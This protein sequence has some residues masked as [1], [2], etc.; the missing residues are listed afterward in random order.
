MAIGLV[1][2]RGKT[3]C[4]RK[5]TMENCINQYVWAYVLTKA[6]CVC[7]CVHTHAHMGMCT[8]FFFFVFFKQT[9]V[10]CSNFLSSILNDEGIVL[11]CMVQGQV[12]LTQRHC[13]MQPFLWRWGEDD[14]SWVVHR[15]F[16]GCTSCMLPRHRLCT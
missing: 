7:V 11:N 15:G 3:T 10:H 8:S 13:L 2:S 9:T 14:K 12:P 6:C 5:L 4:A 1:Y 16:S